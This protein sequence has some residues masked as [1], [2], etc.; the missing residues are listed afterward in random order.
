M[1][2]RNL[3]L[4]ISK[5]PLLRKLT[6]DKTIP[7]SV[8]A[9]LIVEELME[10][11]R[12]TLSNKLTKLLAKG[13]TKDREKIIVDFFK[14]LKT[15]QGYEGLFPTWQNMSEEKKQAFIKAGKK[16]DITKGRAKQFTQQIIAATTPLEIQSGTEELID[17]VEVQTGI[18]LDNTQPAAGKEITLTDEHKLIQRQ[19]N[20]VLRALAKKPFYLKRSDGS[21]SEVV[22]IMFWPTSAVPLLKDKG[23][24]Q[25][26]APGLDKK[27][28][29]QQGVSQMASEKP[30]WN[31]VYKAKSH[32]WVF[33][34]DPEKIQERLGTSR[35]YKVLN[36]V[37]IEELI[38]AKIFLSVEKFQK[39][40]GKTADDELEKDQIEKPKEPESQPKT[41]EIIKQIADELIVNNANIDW[42]Q[43]D[44]ANVIDLV[45]KD[46]EL[47]PE[48][49]EEIQTAPTGQQEEIIAAIENEVEKQTS[50]KPAEQPQGDTDNPEAF[51]PEAEDLETLITTSKALIDEFYDKDFLQE[52]GILINAVLK[53]LAKIVEKE[54]QE[55]AARRSKKPEQAGQELQEQDQEPFSK[56]ERRNI[57]I[58]LKSF[59]RLIKKAKAVLK[60]FDDLRNKGSIASSGYKK[61]FIKILVQLQGNIKTLVE[62]LTPYMNLTEAVEKSDLQ[63]KWDAIE[64]GYEEAAGYL[65]NIIQAGTETQENFDMENNVKGAYGALM[66]ITGYFPSVNPFGAKTTSGFDEYENNFNEAVDE[67]KGTIRDILEVTKGTI[68]R[69]ATQNAIQGLKTFSGQIQNI[70]GEEARSTFSDVVIK[71]NAPAAETGEAP[72][73]EEPITQPDAERKGDDS[74]TIPIHLKAEEHLKEKG[75]PEETIE[76]IIDVAEAAIE[77]FKKQNLDQT[78]IIKNATEK[79]MSEL[80]PEDETIVSAKLTTDEEKREATA[81]LFKSMQDDS[82]T[83]MKEKNLEQVLDSKIE[84]LQGEFSEEEKEYTD[85]YAQ[86]IFKFFLNKNKIGNKDNPLYKSDFLV[87]A[88]NQANAANQNLQ[89]KE[90]NV[91]GGLAL[92]ADDQKEIKK[93]LPADQLKWLQKYRKETNA[94][95]YFDYHKEEFG[96]LVLLMLDRKILKHFKAEDSPQPSPTS[97]LSIQDTFG[98]TSEEMEAMEKFKKHLSSLKEQLEMTDSD[99]QKYTKYLNSLSGEDKKHFSS[100]MKKIGNSKKQSDFRNWLG[101]GEPEETKTYK[102]SSSIKSDD[103]SDGDTSSMGLSSEETDIIKTAAEET[104][105]IVRKENPKATEQEIQDKTEAEVLKAPDVQALV[106][107]EEGG[108]KV[109][110]AVEKTVEKE[111]SPDE[112]TFPLDKEFIT[113]A[114]KISK[115]N[116]LASVLNDTDAAQQRNNLAEEYRQLIEKNKDDEIEGGGDAP[117]ESFLDGKIDN[118]LYRFIGHKPDELKTYFSEKEIEQ[119]AKHYD[120]I[121]LGSSEDQPIYILKPAV[122][123]SDGKIIKGEAISAPAVSK[124]SEDPEKEK[125]AAIDGSFLDTKKKKPK[126]TIESIKTLAESFTKLEDVENDFIQNFDKEKADEQDKEEFV[127]F[128]GKIYSQELVERYNEGKFDLFEETPGSK[129]NQLKTMLYEKLPKELGI[130]IPK[131]YPLQQMMPFED[132]SIKHDDVWHDDLPVAPNEVELNAAG[133]KVRLYDSEKYGFSARNAVGSFTGFKQGKWRAKLVEFTGKRPSKDIEEQ[134]ANKLKPLI[135]EMLT[136]GK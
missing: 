34:I 92:S 116:T 19:L 100:A 54:E 120:S 111:V 11:E 15:G 126:S 45:L 94:G 37:R 113:L 53:Q 22:G 87:R 48:V 86:A 35:T 96:E 85:A 112:E 114:N 43:D 98:L 30:L 1:N 32:S 42:S 107:K 97:T 110:A 102:A 68:G 76:K 28:A 123:K 72:A 71:P 63:K 131:V 93:L 121:Q 109:K 17:D 67:V 3:A 132:N 5:H 124:K 39:L 104:M 128:I 77:E 75:I 91:I 117:D 44:P 26:D 21:Y 136:K 27:I 83:L 122:I 66:S 134:L 125:K 14:V 103:D 4:L 58:D 18:D 59:L 51:D 29:L 65:S 10:A 2:K 129:L 36:D 49:E 13:N 60:K 88:R 6:E 105:A 24:P 40:K 82:D 135:K 95:K 118:K 16:F 47:E 31:D 130:K 80:E 70:F 81:I 64:A 46:V 127:G 84:K 61:D 78:E 41:P 106:N 23:Y 69:T 115:F 119:I 25:Y 62:D 38:R 74:E 99:R 7:N 90:S 8:V 52:Q 20:A 50:E 101:F 9:R 57:Q 79:V 108:E 133:V 33:F 55:K 89:E 56:K 73:A 12:Q